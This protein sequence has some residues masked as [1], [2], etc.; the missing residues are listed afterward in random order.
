MG[1]CL[2]LSCSWFRVRISFR[3]GVSGMDEPTGSSR[4]ATFVALHP[5]GGRGLTLLTS[6]DPARWFAPLSVRPGAGRRQSRRPVRL[7]LVS[8]PAPVCGVSRQRATL[9][10][11]LPCMV[12]WTR[13]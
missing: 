2:D 5:G 8:G 11:T 12:N 13:C 7:R 6:S 1:E 3:S 10:P 4:T 9:H